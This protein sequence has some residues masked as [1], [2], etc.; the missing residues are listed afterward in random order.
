[1]K[2]VLEMFPPKNSFGSNV[3]WVPYDKA[4]QLNKDPY[5]NRPIFV[6]IYSNGCGACR[7]KLILS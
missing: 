1:M 5:D 4:L 2:K 7:S 6:V 3:D